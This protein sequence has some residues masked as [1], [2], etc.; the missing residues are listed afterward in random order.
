MRRSGWRKLPGNKLQAVLT[1]GMSLVLLLVF[2]KAV[3][4]EGPGGETP[5]PAKSAVDSDKSGAK[6]LKLIEEASGTEA[7][8]AGPALKK[9]ARKAKKTE[10]RARRREKADRPRRDGGYRL[11]A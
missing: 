5:A 9:K 11:E 7:Q 4:Q 2:S 1:A 6:V 8:R 3:A 10:A